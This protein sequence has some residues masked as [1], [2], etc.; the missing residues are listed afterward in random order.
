[1]QFG[2]GYGYGN[3]A[4]HDV[5]VFI[6][7]HD[8]QRELNPYVL[9]YKERDQYALCVGFMLAWNYGL[10]RIMSSYVFETLDQGP[11]NY[12]QSRNYEVCNPYHYCKKKNHPIYCFLINL[13]LKVERTSTS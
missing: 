9:N 11:P 2:A 1:M 4:S 8:N 12:G 13:T 6:D 10:P 5:L 3:L 7:N